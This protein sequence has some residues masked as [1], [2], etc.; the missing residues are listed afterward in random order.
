MAAACILLAHCELEF[1]IPGSEDCP[2][3][4]LRCSSLETNPCKFPGLGQAFV[5][6]TALLSPYGLH[7]E[8]EQVKVA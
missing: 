8:S 2:A 7:I 4:S 6:E 1:D 3:L 5:S